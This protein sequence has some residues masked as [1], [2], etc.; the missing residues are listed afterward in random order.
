MNIQFKVVGL[1][2]LGSK[3]KST[4][5]EADALITRPPELYIKAILANFASKT[6]FSVELFLR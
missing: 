2:R 6:T 4:A 5:A 1:T 3:P